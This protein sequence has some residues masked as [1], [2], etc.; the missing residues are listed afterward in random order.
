LFF[1]SSSSGRSSGCGRSAGGRSIELELKE[2]KKK[3]LLR[4]RLRC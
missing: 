4:G 1:P 3:M 2:T